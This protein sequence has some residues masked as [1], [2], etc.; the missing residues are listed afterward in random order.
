MRRALVTLVAGLA[1]VAGACSGGG[2]SPRPS[3]PPLND[4]FERLDGTRAGFADY[5]GTPVVVNFFSTTCIP[6]RTE[7]PDLQKVHEELGSQVA[8]VGMNAEDTVEDGKALVAETGVT[9]DIGRDPRDELLTR[10]GGIG[11]PTTLLLDRD[12]R[13][14]FTHTGKLTADDLRGALRDHKLIS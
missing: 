8:F 2:G 5:R 4:T 7:M 12:G 3:G 9:W 11:L 14:V 1:L 10:L 6:C 13:V